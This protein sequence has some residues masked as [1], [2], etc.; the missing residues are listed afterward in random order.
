MRSFFGFASS[1]ACLLAGLGRLRFVAREYGM[2]RAFFDSVAGSFFF[3]G[4]PDGASILMCVVRAPRP[5]ACCSPWGVWRVRSSCEIFRHTEEMMDSG[6]GR[7]SAGLWAGGC[8]RWTAATHSA[9]GRSVGPEVV[10]CVCFLCLLRTVG[11]APV[12]CRGVRILR[13]LG[14]MLVHVRL[15]WWVYVLSASCGRSG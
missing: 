6:V 10:V 8:G 2:R 13:S 3:I 1:L 12:L 11:F 4:T 5:R 7:V 9:V 15:L 14:L